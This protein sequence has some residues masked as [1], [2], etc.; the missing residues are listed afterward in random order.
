MGDLPWRGGAASAD[1]PRNLALPP[2]AMPLLRGGR[3]LKRWRYVGVFGERVMVCVGY[4]RVLGVPQAWWAVWDRSRGVLSDRT[5]FVRPARGV[6]FSRG[7]VRVHDRDVTIE[8]VLDEGPGVETVCSHGSQYVWTRK[9]AGVAAHGVVRVGREAIPV[10]ALAVI[11]DTAGYHARETAWRWSAGVGSAVD[12]RVVGWNLVEGVN[13]PPRCSE[14]SV[15]IDGVARE[16][17][18]V[19]FAPALESVEFSEGG[20]LRFAAEATRERHDDLV[21][22]RSDYVQPFGTFAGV[23]PD[24]VELAAGFGVMEDHRAQW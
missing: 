15:W 7:R 1:R 5:L 6:A 13:D 18:P 9:Q 4:A 23:L 14:R 10:D 22:A 12:G 16:L 21:I 8:V 3:P 17:G 19:T 11:D 2:V 20:E 24:G